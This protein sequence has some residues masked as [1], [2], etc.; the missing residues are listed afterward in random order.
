M[1]CLLRLGV[2]ISALVSTL[3]CDGVSAEEMERIIA[4]DSILAGNAAIKL[5]PSYQDC[6]DNSFID[7]Y[8]RLQCAYD[9]YDFQDARLNAVYKRLM[10]SLPPPAKLALRAEERTWIRKRRRR[11]D[12]GID[13]PPDYVVEAADCEVSEAAKRSTEL[14]RRLKNS[15]M[16]H[17]RKGT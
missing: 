9:E 10:E 12:F 14:E 5:R 15:T 6:L 1:K 3:A 11:C 4:S 2:A 8:P 13:P 7:E 17:R 16:E